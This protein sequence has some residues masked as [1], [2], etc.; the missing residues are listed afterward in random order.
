[1][2]EEITK[3]RELATALAETLAERMGD[4]IRILDLRGLSDIADWFVIASAQSPRHLRT[5]GRDLFEEIRTAH[6]GKCHAEGLD[7][8]SW[9]ILDLF[10]VVVHIFLP[11]KRDYYALDDYWADAPTEIFELDVRE[12]DDA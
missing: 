5:L 4:D 3:G 6:I 9:V 2:T 10:D 11:E 1:M 8:E 7:S 12:E